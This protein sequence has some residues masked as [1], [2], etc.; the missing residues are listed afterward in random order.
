MRI[1]SVAVALFTL[2]EMLAAAPLTTAERVQF[3]SGKVYVAQNGGLKEAREEVALPFDI[4]V[5]TNGAFTVKSGKP[6]QLQDGEMLDRNGML[7]RPDGTIQPVMDHVT[8]KRNRMVVVK[9]GVV[10]DVKGRIKLGDGSTVSSD[11]YLTSPRGTVRKVLDGELFRL[12]GGNLPVRDTVTM[13]DGRVMVQKDGS[14]LAV[15]RNSTIMMNDGTKVFSDGTII[16]FDGSKSKLREGETLVIE[17]VR[18]R[19][20]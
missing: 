8:M 12:E 10:S 7:L 15:G 18:T 4:L 16:R 17:G 1:I 19:P 9:D 6:R 2:I 5:Q 20:R 14:T 11:G 3:K 13:Q